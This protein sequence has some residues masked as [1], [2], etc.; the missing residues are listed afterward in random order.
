MI[1]EVF[2]TNVVH[3]AHASRLVDQIHKTFTDY[4][5]NF[6]LEDCDH[7]LRV[8]G[9]KG[10]VDAFLLI[11]LL[12]DSGFHAQVLPDEDQPASYTELIRNLSAR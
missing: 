5:A 3:Q 6:D 4:K 9:T 12:K 1:V 8:V 2:K 11:D 10:F 7:I